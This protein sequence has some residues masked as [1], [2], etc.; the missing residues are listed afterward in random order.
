MSD[1]K[2]TNP[3]DE[4]P[5]GRAA[6][7]RK[8]WRRRLARLAAIALLLLLG[9]RLGTPLLL[10][11]ILHLIGESLELEIDYEALDL[12]LMRGEIAIHGLSVESPNND[13][14][15]V[16][17]GYLRADFD[18]GDL[19]GGD[20][21]VERLEI[22][23][24]ELTV[25][26]L[27]DGRLSILKA[28]GPALSKPAPHKG[29]APEPAARAWA[30]AP[31]LELPVAIR[32][33]RLNAAH[34]RFRD[35]ARPEPF[36]GTLDID[37][38]L[39]DLG[40]LEGHPAVLEVTASSAD[41][42]DR[43]RIE[44]RATLLERSVDCSLA[45]V[46]DNL[47]AEPLAEYI[48]LLGLRS[49][50]QQ[51]SLSLEARAE[52]QQSAVTP[53]VTG[54]LVVGPLRVSPDGAEAVTL[55]RLAVEF[56]ELGAERV[57]L[58][59]VSLEGLGVEL[60]RDGENALHLAGVVIPLSAPSRGEASEPPESGMAPVLEIGE[61]LASD[62]QV[63]LTDLAMGPANELRLAVPVLR[64]ANLVVD[65]ESR[66][67]E[68][69]SLEGRLVAPGVFDE[70]TLR[71]TLDPFGPCL[72][73]GLTLKGTGLQSHTIAPYLRSIGIEPL[74][75]DGTLT[76]SVS[77]TFEESPGSAVIASARVEDLRLRD[78]AQDLFELRQLDFD[79]L[80]LAPGLESVRLQSLLLNG[81]QARVT[82]EASGDVVAAGFRFKKVEGEL[83]EEAAPAAP[84]PAGGP[85]SWRLP[86]IDIARLQAGK[87]RLALRD[88]GCVPATDLQLARLALEVT[89]VT[90]TPLPGS[91]AGRIALV[92][93]LPS[94]AEHI[95]V[96][97]AISA[98]RTGAKI[99]LAVQGDGLTARAIAPY[100]SVAGVTPELYDGRLQADLVA[101]V[102][103]N[104]GGGPLLDVNV[105]E[106]EWSDQ[107]RTLLRVGGL[108]L[109]SARV[110]A[111]A[112]GPTELSLG[113]LALARLETDVT[114]EERG[115]V[116]AWGFRVETAPP[117]GDSSAPEPLRNAP[118]PN[119][120]FFAGEI[121]VG[122]VVC[123]VRLDRGSQPLELPL[124]FSGHAG[125]L[126]LRPSGPSEPV[127]FLVS[128]GLADA[129]ESLELGGTIEAAFDRLAV[130]AHLDAGGVTLKRLAPLLGVEPEWDRGTI[131]GSIE[132]TIGIGAE[133]LSVAARIEKLSV[134]DGDVELVGVDTLS[135]EGST[136]QAGGLAIGH[137]A[138][139]APRVV[140]MREADGT[141]KVAG[142]RFPHASAPGGQAAPPGGVASELE[143]V[144]SRFRLDGVR[145]TQARLVVDDRY[146]D[147]ETHFEGSA[148]VTLDGFV[149]G[150][151][152]PPA[153]FDIT[154][155]L[156]PGL[157]RLSLK[158][159]LHPSPGHQQ[160]DLVLAMEGIRGD[161]FLPYLS[162]GVMPALQDGVLQAT[163]AADLHD[164]VEGGQV[165][166][167]SVSGFD[168]RERGA[169]LPLLAFDGLR[170][171]ADRLDPRVE[172]EFD[173]VSIEGLEGSVETRPD[174]EVRLLGL[175]LRG[176][177][178]AEESVATAPGALDAAPALAAPLSGPERT[179]RLVSDLEQYE[180]PLLEIDTLHVGVRRIAW[181][182]PT[183]PEE[184]PVDI[185]V[186]LNN[187]QPIRLLGAD[188]DSR[189]PIEM[190][191]TLEA[192][193]LVGPCELKAKVLSQTHQLS[194]ELDW[195]AQGIDGS[196]LLERVPGLAGVASRA[197]LADG[198]FQ[199]SL[200]LLARLPRGA[201][202]LHYDLRNGFGVDLIVEN[203][204]L[205]DGAGG[206]VLA[207]FE[208]LTIEAGQVTPRRNEVRI[209]R[210]GLVE[211]RGRVWRGADG[212][213][214]LGLVLPPGQG[215]AATLAPSATPPDEVPGASATG[216]AEP[217]RSEPRDEDSFVVRIDQIHAQG[218]RL[219]YEDTS[220]APP[221]R[222]PIEG[223]ELEVNG[224]AQPA[225]KNERPVNFEVQ[226]QAGDVS[227]PPRS[228]R[229]WI[230]GTVAFVGDVAKS[231]LGTSE[232]EALESRPL[233][234]DITVNGVI[235]MSPRLAGTISG[236]VSGLELAALRGLAAGAG[237]ELSDG[238]LDA[239]LEADFRPDGI[240][241]SRNVLILASLDVAE[242]ADGPIQKF[243][244]LPAPLN[245]AVFALKDDAGALRIPVDFEMSSEGLSGS[246]VFGV[247]LDSFSRVIVRAVE[248]LGFRAVG[249]VMD[250]G[251]S[252]ISR[253]PLIGSV[254][255]WIFVGGP[256]PEDFEP[257]EIDFDSCEAAVD[258]VA[259]E[260]LSGVLERLDDYDE[261]VVNIR[262][263][264]GSG[265]LARVEQMAMVE[266]AEARELVSLLQRRKLALERT[267][268]IEL[269]QERALVLAGASKQEA[270]SR[271]RLRDLLAKQGLIDQQLERLYEV[272]GDVED[273]WR[274]RRVRALAIELGR[275]RLERAR[276]SLLEL[277]KELSGLADRIII[278][279]PRY[280]K[281]ERPGGGRI[282][283]TPR[284]VRR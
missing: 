61:I 238:V 213:H 186:G 78:G 110:A 138:I 28:L 1:T 240:L 51:L 135:V 81:L 164:H 200:D 157:E 247:A 171:V 179:E 47:R 104:G 123:T 202:P 70:L 19:L 205:R 3:E 232:G 36:E 199:G 82:R 236:Q 113:R 167:L 163:L 224:W 259:R 170:I 60:L 42:L 152:S 46:V 129:V 6:S 49:A 43:L 139:E 243:L 14:N 206:D 93:E 180:L 44:S 56:T 220:A 271:Q 207:G 119:T 229:D 187:V 140:A 268:Q 26:R 112:A 117:A 263:E 13:I 121:D 72:R 245:L 160:L 242:P 53:G 254:W 35:R 146:N 192:A 114:M 250:L 174:G 284:V 109:A 210:V 89:N 211:P 225:Q 20:I 280:E 32:A 64:V 209:G 161:A 125:P 168:F 86:E 147:R 10:P 25:E 54:R 214:I 8:R 5:Q 153:S 66:P 265:D 2:S 69:A 98:T 88:E 156:E 77:G 194:L 118:E 193:P 226:L 283:I 148:D 99:E 34:I 237:I 12:S 45:V 16:Q 222:V 50:A 169:P 144:P 158:G 155:R 131:K 189:P 150:Q 275:I 105:K 273:R 253:I 59:V 52:A 128:L 71:G 122:D 48:A 258:G 58:P 264:L 195:Q 27:A 261:L 7:Q 231:A 218:A 154:V 143:R 111:P 39:S 33:L 217:A 101:A 124:H 90:T 23:G 266:K 255:N 184:G 151:A 277:G 79:N 267:R 116:R 95:A 106:L 94:V 134:S 269:A 30:G 130:H 63:R 197:D 185:K 234:E 228:E 188:P 85:V 241:A 166:A 57:A 230:E 62:V 276:A 107:G 203:V 75:E 96:E 208:E 37:V 83:R 183:R 141:L 67:D 31:L 84:L 74:L 108:E 182:D 145:V 172:L 41:L 38:R 92:A 11:W 262:H 181:S 175:A 257:V 219:L 24:A 282:V 216:T 40:T 221:L 17:V 73:A 159:E 18:L 137:A 76:L 239:T 227:L 256:Y 279:R 252:V 142:L 233:F 97:G 87:I 178:A 198:R 127:P 133:G 120:A 91:E 68:I 274:A 162:A 132:G 215:E 248:R 249:F 149:L 204:D 136:S 246:S 191:L 190:R 176:M 115:L 223:L 173:T 270:A 126:A 196:K 278:M 251:G 102:D 15:S 55:R 212:W 21:V 272:L 244:R 201:S 65:P 80:R 4:R 9:L 29:S 165:G 281:T 22:D 177:P 235:E 103:L 260:R 100:L